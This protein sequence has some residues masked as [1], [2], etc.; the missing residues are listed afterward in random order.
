MGK[1]HAELAKEVARHRSEREATRQAFQEELVAAQE[2]EEAD[3]ARRREEETEAAAAAEAAQASALA[4]G[5]DDA[6]LEPAKLRQELAA[7]RVRT[8]GLLAE[9]SQEADSLRQQ[10]E[11]REEQLRRAAKT[12]R[13]EAARLAPLDCAEDSSASGDVLSEL[14]ARVDRLGVEAKELRG[15][16]AAAE[17]EAGALRARNDE[18]QQAAVEADAARRE[19]DGDSQREMQAIKA[20][21]QR[22][23]TQL[24]NAQEHSHQ[25]RSQL[26]NHLHNAY[27]GRLARKELRE[28]GVQ[29]RYAAEDDQLKEKVRALSEELEEAKKRRAERAPWWALCLRGPEGGRGP[30]EAA[31]AGAGAALMRAAGLGDSAAPTM[32]ELAGARPQRP[33]GRPAAG[34]PSAASTP[35]PALGSAAGPAGERL[36]KPGSIRS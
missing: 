26:R 12:S 35:S 31:A 5:G 28:Q 1:E 8:E 36:P 25:L 6:E 7:E 21:S 32:A 27:D 13:A 10:L 22:L 18:A 2:R 16:K 9:E 20:E 29:T 19:R 30:A 24:A 23:L 34:L 33:A 4:H 11:Q 14:R 17:G 3:A 15:A